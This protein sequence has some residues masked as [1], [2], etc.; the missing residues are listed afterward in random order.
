MLAGNR[1]GRWRETEKSIKRL[2]RAVFEF[3]LSGCREE[4]EAGASLDDTN[5][6][7]LP[8]IVTEADFR[9]ALEEAICCFRGFRKQSPVL[10]SLRDINAHIDPFLSW[11]AELRD[12]RHRDSILCTSSP[13]LSH[14]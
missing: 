1:D 4:S 8:E 9:D 12:G 5:D 2:N 14:L 13:D 3:Q 10:A 7:L 11:L 6:T